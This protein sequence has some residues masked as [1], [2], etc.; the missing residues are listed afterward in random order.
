MPT[1]KIYKEFFNLFKSMSD[2]DLRKKG[3]YVQKLWNKGSLFQRLSVVSCKQA[4]W[5]V[6][7][8]YGTYFGRRLL[9]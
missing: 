5:N 3:K 2:K 1:C 4:L 6:N 8:H 9:I 7:I